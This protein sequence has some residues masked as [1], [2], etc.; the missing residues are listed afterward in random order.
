MAEL[1]SPWR[2]FL[3]DLDNLVAEPV[4]LHCLG[5]FVVRFHYGLLARVTGDIDYYTAVPNIGNLQDLAGPT[6]SLANKRKVYLQRVTVAELPEDY[7]SRL[8]EMFPKHFRNLRL[9]APDPY[10]LMLSKLERNS[11]KDREDAAY[12]FQ[13]QKLNV[14]MLEQRYQ[15]ALRPNLSNPAREDLTLKLWLEM[16]QA[17]ADK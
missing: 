4:A 3:T 16:F 14:V 10:D 6:S 1:P 13:S 2:D 15:Q 17:E 9:Y 7:E 5:G 8:T 12:L 11:G